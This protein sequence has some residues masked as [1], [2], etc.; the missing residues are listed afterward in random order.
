VKL[1]PPEVQM[2]ATVYRLLDALKTMNGALEALAEI[3]APTDLQAGLS[4][5]LRRM[6]RRCEK[7]SRKLEE[8][9]VRKFREN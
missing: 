9:M 7:A 3:E 5:L 6:I 2:Y 4:V 8:Q 1:D